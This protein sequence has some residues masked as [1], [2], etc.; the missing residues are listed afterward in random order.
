VAYGFG[1]TRKL[2]CLDSASCYREFCTKSGN[3][4]L[5]KTLPTGR[6]IT[7]CL[8]KRHARMSTTVGGKQSR[9]LSHARNV[10]FRRV[11]AQDLYNNLY[12]F[13]A[14]VY[15]EFGQPKGG[16]AF[17]DV[18]P[19]LMQIARSQATEPR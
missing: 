17:G 6:R 7:V 4:K 3:A 1:R 19:R 8:G 10:R 2:S 16:S 5:M 14:R 9:A 15:F 18:L 13:I 11:E 12:S